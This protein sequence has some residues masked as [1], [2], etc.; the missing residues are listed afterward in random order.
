VGLLRGRFAIESQTGKGA[1]I[2]VQV[3]L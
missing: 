2:T 3:P 1:T